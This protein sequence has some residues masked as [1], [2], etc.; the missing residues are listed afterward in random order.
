METLK[1]R[2]TIS[3]D[4]MVEAYKNVIAESGFLGLWSGSSS[5]TVE[6]ALLGAFFMLGSTITKQR[7][8]AAGGSKTIAA[9][10]G[11]TV[12]GVAQAVVMTPAGMIFTSLNANRGKKGYEGDNAIIVANRI[13]KEKGI[14]GTFFGGGPMCARQASNWASRA[15]F[16]EIA[17][18]TLGMSKYGVL[19]E[20]GS[21]VIGGLGSCWY[22]SFSFFLF[23]SIPLKVFTNV[24]FL[25]WGENS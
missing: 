14:R 6:G 17:R 4:N 22:V 10:A 23:F 24:F 18:T 25:F 9:L 7:V 12:G 3:K 11:G 15:G 2:V 20:I 8:L 13:I 16:T 5:R 21:G 1:C 19:G